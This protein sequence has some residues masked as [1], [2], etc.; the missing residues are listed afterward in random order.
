MRPVPPLVINLLAGFGFAVLVSKLLGWV[1]DV[2]SEMQLIV[3]AI[4]FAGAFILLAI[5]NVRSSS[6]R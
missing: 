3:F 6:H 2:G 4:A 1:S 5:S